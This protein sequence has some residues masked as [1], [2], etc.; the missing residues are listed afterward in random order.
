MAVTRYAVLGTSTKNWSSTSA[1]ST[2]SG[3]ATGASAPGN[4]D[5]AIFNSASGSGTMTLDAGVSTLADLDMVGNGVFT[6][7]LAM[8]VNT[9]ITVGATLAGTFTGTGAAEIQCSGD[10]LYAT[11]ADDWT[12]FDGTVIATWGSTTDPTLDSGGENPA[13]PHFE[14]DNSGVTSFVWQNT[15]A[16]VCSQFTMTGGKFDLNSKGM[17]VTGDIA[18]IPGGTITNSGTVSQTASGT[19]SWAELANPA[20]HM[21]L[22]WGDGVDSTLNNSVFASKFSY[23]AGTVELSNRTLYVYNPTA[24]NFWVDG[25]GSVETASTGAV[26][27]E[28]TKGDRENGSITCDCNLSIKGDADT[29]LTMT[30]NIDIGTKTLTIWGG[31]YGFL[32]TM[33]TS[34][35][36]GDTTIAMGDATYSRA[37]IIDFGSGDHV[38]AGIT[39]LAGGGNCGIAFN[40]AN[41]NL[42][43]TIDGANMRAADIS[44]TC[45]AIHGGTISNLDCSSTNE[46]NAVNGVTEGTGNTDVAF[47]GDDSFPVPGT[48]MLMG[49]GV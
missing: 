48:L 44:N 25:S 24:D 19:V 18:H 22:A 8:G 35:V 14:V 28:E 41:I 21:R 26:N 29:T 1:W 42:S 45:A 6:G 37:A 46:L 12:G 40:T 13:L 4:T 30:G 33:G 39:E 16:M 36:T 38:I 7:T 49:A 23:G 3:G 5:S 27:I 31:N 2:S 15:A 9:L 11:S 20:D 32:L 10:L 34:A 43:G 47:E 17:T